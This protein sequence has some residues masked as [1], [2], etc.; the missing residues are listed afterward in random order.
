MLKINY[1]QSWVSPIVLNGIRHSFCSWDK[2][3]SEF[4]LRHKKVIQYGEADIALMDR[5]INAGPPHRKFLRQIPI[6]MDITAPDYW[7]KQEAT[8]KIGTTENSTSTMH[9]II[10]KEFELSDFSIDEAGNLGWEQIIKDLNIL[11][12]LYLKLSDPE[13]KERVWRNIIQLLPMAY[14]YRR[15]VSLNAEV[16][17]NMCEQRASHK[18][19]EWHQF[20]DQAKG[21]WEKENPNIKIFDKI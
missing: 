9:T 7:W 6:I 19:I 11:R 20:I 18:L 3:D 16:L 21:Y 1:F 5:L 8:Y 17:L 13:K 15:S 10:S 12:D 2:S 14:N 4:S